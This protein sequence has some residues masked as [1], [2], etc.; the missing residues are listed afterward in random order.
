M[1][2]TNKIL[3]AEHLA[4][5]GVALMRGQI[6]LPQSMRAMFFFVVLA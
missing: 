2:L 1:E 3:H 4:T 5:N 6:F